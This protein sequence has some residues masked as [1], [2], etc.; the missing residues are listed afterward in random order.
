VGSPAT[1]RRRAPARSYFVFTISKSRGI[2]ASSA[3]PFFRRKQEV[4]AGKGPGSS[5]NRLLS[6]VRKILGT[7]SNDDQIGTLSND[8][9]KS[10][11]LRYQLLAPTF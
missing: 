6:S 5:Q 9:Q 2:A 10:E 11:G 7:L 4:K 1:R 3:A 8:N